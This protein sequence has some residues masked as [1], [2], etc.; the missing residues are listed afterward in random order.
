[1]QYVFQGSKLIQSQQVL[2]KF[3]SHK[4]IPV[5]MPVEQ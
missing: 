4:V 2:V 1:M 3:I 5:A